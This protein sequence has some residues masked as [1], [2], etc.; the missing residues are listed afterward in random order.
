[1]DYISISDVI[2]ANASNMGQISVFIDILSDGVFECEERFTVVIESSDTNVI[3]GRCVTTVTI[4]DI[5]I[6]TEGRR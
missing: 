4:I 3:F 2:V 5:I 1:M 6:P